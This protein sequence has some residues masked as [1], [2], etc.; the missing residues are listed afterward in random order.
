M[1]VCVRTTVNLPDELVSRAKKIAAE[2]RITLTALIEEGLHEAIA[3][4]KRG[5]RREPLR[6]TTYGAKGPLPGVDLDD[7]AALLDVMDD[8]AG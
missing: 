2:S 4:R 6:L 5:S 7:S 3:R 1:F 8:G